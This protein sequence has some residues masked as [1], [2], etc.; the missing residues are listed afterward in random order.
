MFQVP[1]VVNLP[2]SA[3]QVIGSVDSQGT[4]RS[5]RPHR[6]YSMDH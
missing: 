3:Q 1:G 4:G 5:L 2:G 6:V